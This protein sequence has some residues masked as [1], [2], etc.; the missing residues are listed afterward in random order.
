MAQVNNNI[1][2]YF[3]SNLLLQIGC[4]VPAREA[5]FRIADRIFSRIGF[6]DN[7]ESNSSSLMVEVGFK[8]LQKIKP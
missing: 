8:F 7:I 6:D 1:K 3:C 2:K 5:S 4:Y